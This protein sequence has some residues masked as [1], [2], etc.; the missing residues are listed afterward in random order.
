MRT[1]DRGTDWG[2][3]SRV[4]AIIAVVL[5]IGWAVVQSSLV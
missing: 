5:G 3:R 4:Y 2:R 1:I